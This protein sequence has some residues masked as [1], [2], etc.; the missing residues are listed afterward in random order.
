MSQCILQCALYTVRILIYAD[1]LLFIL[2]YS[3]IS[4]LPYYYHYYYYYYYTSIL[5]LLLFLLSL[6]LLL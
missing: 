1:P 2:Q 3:P 5:L 4:L 6:L